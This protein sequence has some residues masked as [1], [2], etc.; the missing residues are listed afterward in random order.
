MCNISTGLHDSLINVD[1][2]TWNCCHTW[3]EQQGEQHSG[4]VVGTVASQQEDPGFDTSWSRGPFCVE[5]ER[6]LGTPAS[7]HSLKT[8]RLIG[9]SKLSVGV[10]V[11][12]NGSFTQ[13]FTLL[14]RVIGG[15][16]QS[17]L[18]GGEGWIHPGQ[19]TSSSQGWQTTIHAHIHT[20]GQLRVTNEPNLH[21]LDHVYTGATYS[22]QEDLYSASS[23]YAESA[24][25]CM[26]GQ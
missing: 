2:K 5:F 16:S 3:V 12:V 17:Q 14:C 24:V 9:D 8:H 7:S 1:C 10:N 18:T 21:V 22:K 19:V 25:V 11:S 20:Y 26:P 13:S 23:K 4:S 15:W 6:S